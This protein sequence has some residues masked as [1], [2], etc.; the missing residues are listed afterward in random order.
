MRTKYA[1]K[2][3]AEGSKV[4]N[5]LSLACAQGNERVLT[6]RR[7]LQSQNAQSEER[8]LRC[9]KQ[10]SKK[11]LFIVN[12]NSLVYERSPLGGTQGV[13][14]ALAARA[15]RVVMSPGLE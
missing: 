12:S 2:T 11:H 3:H 9:R 6:A 15:A 8:R 5:S 14:R 10:G 4:L 1:E 13:S 7:E